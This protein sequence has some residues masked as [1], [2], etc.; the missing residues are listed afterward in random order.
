[1]NI[2][3]GL[4]ASPLCTAHSRPKGFED[5]VTPYGD[6]AYPAT[7]ISWETVKSIR[8]SQTW[9]AIIVA[10]KVNNLLIELFTEFQI[11]KT[12]KTIKII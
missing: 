1:M 7:P 6:S 5:S 11:F 9:M 2:L 3:T 10:I 4:T 8:A 12:P